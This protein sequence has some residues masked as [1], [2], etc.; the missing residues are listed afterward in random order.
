MP[1]GPRDTRFEQVSKSVNFSALFL[2]LGVLSVSLSSAW[3]TCTA[4]EQERREESLW[5]KPNAIGDRGPTVSGPAQYRVSSLY[6]P[7]NICRR[8]GRRN[9]WR[10]ERG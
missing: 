4:G 8:D 5:M 6:C 7:R 1:K 9:G 2:T 10:G 3:R